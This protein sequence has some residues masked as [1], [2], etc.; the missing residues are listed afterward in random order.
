VLDLA[1]IGAHRTAEP[2]ARPGSRASAAS[3]L[4]GTCSPTRSGNAARRARDR[5]CSRGR[6]RAHAGAMP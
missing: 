1:G 5:S 2:R 6:E 4:D 3:S